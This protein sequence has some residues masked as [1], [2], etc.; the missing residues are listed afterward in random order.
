[1]RGLLGS[2]LLSSVTGLRSPFT[3][4][5]ELEEELHDEAEEP[6]EPETA[7]GFEFPGEEKEALYSFLWG[8]GVMV[9]LDTNPCGDGNIPWLGVDCR[10]GSSCGSGKA[11]ASLERPVP[12]PNAGPLGLN[13]P[14]TPPEPDETFGC[15]PGWALEIKNK[16]RLLKGKEIPKAVGNL[17]SLL[18]LD[19]SGNM[20]AGT[21]PNELFSLEQLEALMLSQNQFIDKLDPLL[22]QFVNLRAL[23][24]NENKF[25]GPIPNTMAHLGRLEWLDLHKNRLDGGLSNLRLPRL[26]AL[27]LDNNR[28]DETLPVTLA[29]S[30][31]NL[32]IL[33]LQDNDLYGSIPALPPSLEYAWL[34]RNRLEG[35]LPAMPAQLKAMDC[36]QNFLDGPLPP[37]RACT[38]LYDLRLDRN[39]IKGSIPEDMP[40]TL[41]VLDLSQNN[42]TGTVPASLGRLTRAHR[43]KLQKNEL[44]GKLPKE[45]G[46]LSKVDRLWLSDNHLTGP[47]PAE[48]AALQTGPRRVEL[49]GNMLRPVGSKDLTMHEILAGG[50]V[51]KMETTSTTTT[52]WDGF[53]EAGEQ[54]GWP[55]PVYKTHAGAKPLQISASAVV[56]SLPPPVPPADYVP[57]GSWATTPHQQ[58]PPGVTAGVKYGAGVLPAWNPPP[59]KPD[60]KP[61]L[62]P[63]AS[64]DTACP[65]MQDYYKVKFRDECAGTKARRCTAL[66]LTYG[67]SCSTMCG[68]VEL[69]CHAAYPTITN[70]KCLY[71]TV[72]NSC[73]DYTKTFGIC[74]C[75]APEVESIL[76]T[77]AAKDSATD[78]KGG[79][80]TSAA[81]A[82]AKSTGA[83]HEEGGGD[84]GDAATS[85]AKG[86]QETSAASDA[87]VGSEGAKQEESGGSNGDAASSDAKGDQ[88][89]ATPAS[90]ADAGSESAQS[91]GGG[92]GDAAGA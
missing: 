14:V 92:S 22:G 3:E 9:D 88:Q 7:H 70:S 66:L 53:F 77:T 81:G 83:K 76:G 60:P 38:Q 59:Q 75:R 32:R 27:W 44:S 24:L 65:R 87:D 8:L 41:E 71:G 13:F 48:V 15:E 23:S 57:R 86:E 18:H 33:Q 89:T 62:L 84:K 79:Q 50:G 82:D 29:S 85:D 80:E 46:A 67:Q 1:M 2:L 17:T 11:K 91:E 45:L 69:T 56:D 39:K 68:E 28:I 49:F 37:F 34:S 58:L 64:M 78:A 52:E 5:L 43:I 26:R 74:E 55:M 31:P 16:H 25:H 4:Q 12:E 19:L 6:K 21:L 40:P 90:D 35:A 61:Q 73:D 47:I 72:T 51:P 20:L 54:M 42:L 36:S 63:M 30:L 10:Y